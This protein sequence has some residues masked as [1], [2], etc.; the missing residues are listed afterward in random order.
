MLTDRLT[1]SRG[2]LAQ[3][4]G[5]QARIAKH[6]AA[7]GDDQVA[8]LGH[9]QE[10][11][12]QQQSP[13]RVPPAHER[14][15]AQYRLVLQ[16]DDR[17]V[18]HREVLVGVLQGGAQLG[19]HVQAV[20]GTRRSASSWTSNLL[21]PRRFARYIAV[22]ASRSSRPAA[23]GV[24]P[25][26]IAMP[27]LA[28]TTNHAVHREGAGEFADAA[29]PRPPMPPPR[30]RSDRTRR[31]TRHRRCA[32]RCRPAA[33]RREAGAPR[34]PGRVAGGVPQAVVDRLETVQVDEKHTDPAPVAPG[35][36][37]GVLQ[38]VGEQPTIG[39]PGEGSCRLRWS[40]LGLRRPAL[41]DVLHMHDHARRRPRAGLEPGHASAAP[42]SP[43]PAR[44]VG[45]PHLGSLPPPFPAG[46]PRAGGGRRASRVRSDASLVSSSLSRC[47]SM[48]RAELA[49]SSR[50]AE[51]SAADEGHTDRCP[52]EGPLGQLLGLAPP[53]LELRQQDGDEEPDGHRHDQSAQLHRVDGVAARPA[54]W[55]PTRPRP[56]AQ[57][58]GSRKKDPAIRRPTRP[59]R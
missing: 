30:C 43:G 58:P 20:Q 8:L 11:L 27:M 17:L 24:R 25:S 9:R 10:G 7:E 53:P 50:A 35:A 55:R 41:G 57:R 15:D 52:I 6:P 23:M 32:R 40:Q 56:P 51:P 16:V 36:G 31:R 46:P 14:L 45:P 37:D 39:Q 47:I 2:S 21:R 12:G 42:S 54:K 5:V 49:R 38:P 13:A 29:A 4:R 34:R 19:L 59:G 22:S 1:R 44:P 48:S 18:V 33:V 28:V 26:L 3:R